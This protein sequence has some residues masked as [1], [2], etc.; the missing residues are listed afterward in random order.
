MARRT[1][2][3]GAMEMGAIGPNDKSTAEDFDRRLLFLYRT[4]RV[5]SWDSVLS[6]HLQLAYIRVRYRHDGK[7][8]PEP[9]TPQALDD[10]IQRCKWL[11][12]TPRDFGGLHDVSGH[13]RRLMEG[14]LKD[15]H[16]DLGGPWVRAFLIAHV[17]FV[18]ALIRRCIASTTRPTPTRT[19][20]RSASARC[21]TGPASST[22]IHPPGVDSL[23]GLAMPCLHMPSAIGDVSLPTGRSLLTSAPVV[24][25]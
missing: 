2:A 15:A 14:L 10:A 24:K 3:S 6:C 4:L 18:C 17:R 13:Y 22:A 19:N 5:L 1:F 20:A 23:S 8:E 21:G 9:V 16:V 25:T 11:L 7:A 12:M